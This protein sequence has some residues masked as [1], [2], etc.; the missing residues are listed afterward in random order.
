MHH[1]NALTILS[2]A[3]VVAE[4]ERQRTRIAN[5]DEDIKA[6]GAERDRLRTFRDEVFSALHKSAYISLYALV[7][8]EAA[9]M[10]ASE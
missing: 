3:E 8:A 6:L 2:P 9:A 1:P 7:A 10:E 5:D 4:L